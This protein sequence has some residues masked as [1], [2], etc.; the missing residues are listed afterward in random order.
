MRYANKEGHFIDE[1]GEL[2]CFDP[3][4]YHESNPCLMVRKDKLMEFLSDNNL[5]IC[6]TLIGE[7]QI[8][9]PISSRDNRLGVMQ[10]S[11]HISL[12]GSGIINVKDADSEFEEYNTKI[13][14]EDMNKT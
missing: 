4:I 14:I 13:K 12:D 2:I 8:I 7:K 11:G 10:L 6:W 9:S 3:S 1:G 5:I